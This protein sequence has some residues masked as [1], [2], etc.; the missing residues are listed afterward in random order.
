MSIDPSDL[1]RRW[2]Q[3]WPQCPPIAYRFKTCMHDR[4][5][6]FHSLP[7]SK[8]YA[9]SEAEYEIIL[10]RHNTI[11]RELG[12]TEIYLMTVEYDVDDLAARTEPVHAGL[13]PNA[14]RWMRAADPD[15]PDMA[16]DV[17]VSQLRHEAGVLDDLL[18]YVADD[19]AGHVIVTDTALRWLYHPYDGGA[20]VI[21]PSSTERDQLKAQ[22]SEWLS[23]RHDG[24]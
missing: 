4:W 9:S 1:T 21:L 15:D 7:G 11:L 14:S 20:D 6:R 5:I 16:Y 13:H 3:S 12:A 22:H 17:H 23:D 19:R 24:L 8:R 10:H 2:E 18:R